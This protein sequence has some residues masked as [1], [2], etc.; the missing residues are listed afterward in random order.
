MGRTRAAATIQFAA[1]APIASSGLWVK[2]DDDGDL[3]RLVG[4]YGKRERER[5]L[6]GAAF[7]GDKSDGFHNTSLHVYMSLCLKYYMEQM[8]VYQFEKGLTLLSK[9]ILQSGVTPR[10]RQPAFPGCS[11][12]GRGSRPR[13]AFIPLRAK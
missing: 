13:G 10:E 2:I 3:A 1:V 4:G 6:S 11:S 8:L 9:G 12:P 5:G 7:L